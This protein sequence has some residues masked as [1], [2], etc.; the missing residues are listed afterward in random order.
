MRELAR[1]LGKIVTSFPAVT[2]GPPHYRHLER[3][4]IS[5]L[6]YHKGN[7]EGKISL[8]GKAVSEIHYWINNIDNSSHHIKYIPNPDITIHTYASLT[9]WGIT[10]EIS[11][12]RGLW[13]KAELD[14]INSFQMDHLELKS[15]EIGIYT[16]CKNK[17]FLH[18]RVICD[19]VTST[20]FINNMGGI[21]NETCNTFASRIWNF[22]TENKLWVSAAHIPCKNNLEADEQS[23]ILQDATEWKLHPELFQKIIDKF[24]I[25]HIDLF[26]SRINRQLKRYVSWHPEPEA[27]AVN[28][29]SLNWNNNYFYIPPF[30]LVGRVLAK[31]NRDK[32]EAVIVVPDWSTQYWYPQIMQMTS[33]KPLYFRPSAKNL[34]LTH[35]PSDNHPL[36]LKLQ[37]MA[38]RVMLLLLKF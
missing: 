35:K 16:Y 25:P 10:N 4:K 23:R 24:G 9:G 30:S 13:H 8:S 15:I 36:H 17:I 7:F 14:H 20:A 3:D 33:H 11:P 26:T 19:N 22:C 34:I 27:M 38:V 6:K 31:V 12:S 29:F 37:L 28:A 5:A 32:T 18:V 2:F 21:K 1:I